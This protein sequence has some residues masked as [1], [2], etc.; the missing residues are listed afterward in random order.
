[1]IKTS[2]SFGAKEY[3]ILSIVSFKSVLV[4][5]LCGLYLS[6]KSTIS[7][8]ISLLVSKILASSDEVFTG[9]IKRHLDF[10]IRDAQFFLNIRFIG[11]D[12]VAIL[13]FR[14]DFLVFGDEFVDMNR[15]PH[16][17]YL[18]NDRFRDILLDPSNRECRKPKSFAMIKFFYRLNQS[19]IS[20]L[21]Q[22]RQMKMSASIM[23]SDVNYEPIIF[24]DHLIF[25]KFLL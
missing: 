2:F 5:S 9:Q 22:I 20:L 25:I 17:F 13:I 1:M 12:T 10:F 4:V 3:R 7:S 19:K 14:D 6:S 15:N 18:I 24:L 16:H 23:F 8:L 21:D 11:F